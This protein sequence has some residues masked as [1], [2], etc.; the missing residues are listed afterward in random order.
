MAGMTKR[1]QYR[2]YVEQ[3]R[4][5]G[6]EL[7]RVRAEELRRY[8][9]DPADADAVI[10]MGDSCVGPPRLTSGLVEMQRLFMKAARRQ[11]LLP[12]LVRE[13]GAVYSLDDAGVRNAAPKGGMTNP[14]RTPPK[15]H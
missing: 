11:G 1:E 3:W 12:A 8:R 13:E 14:S 15:P 9:Y 2:A 4:R 7:E 5:A 6:P 10:E